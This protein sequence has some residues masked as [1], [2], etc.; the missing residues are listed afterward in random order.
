MMAGLGFW[1]RRGADKTNFHLLIRNKI[2]TQY[3]LTARFDRTLHEIIRLGCL[4]RASIRFFWFRK[5]LARYK[6][7][8]FFRLACFKHPTVSEKQRS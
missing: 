5:I 6:T 4:L 7:I 2:E 8:C 3:T 1:S